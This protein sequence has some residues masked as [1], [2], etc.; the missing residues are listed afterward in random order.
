MTRYG[1]KRINKWKKFDK[2]NLAIALNV[3]YVKKI[4]IQKRTQTMN[5]KINALMIP[6]G[7]GCHYLT[8]KN[9]YY[10]HYYEAKNNVKT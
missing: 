5:K 8:V 3:L 9:H 10:H 4:N 6:N 2:N 7:D 1:Q